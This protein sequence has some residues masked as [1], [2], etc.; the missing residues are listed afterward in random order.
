LTKT[1][2]CDLHQAAVEDF[3]RMGDE[4]NEAVA[5]QTL[6]NLVE[7]LESQKESYFG[8]SASLHKHNLQTA[9]QVLRAGEDDDTAVA[10]LFHDVFE[11][12]AVKN[13]GELASAMLAPWLSPKQR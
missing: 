1:P 13:Q 12:L 3:D 9:S 5:E 11:T 10:S 7:L 2:F 4:R 6:D 8:A